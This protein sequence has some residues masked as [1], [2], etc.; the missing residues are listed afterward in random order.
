MKNTNAVPQMLLDNGRGQEGD[1]RK[2]SK[3]LTF[4]DRRADEWRRAADRHAR[5]GESILAMMF[6]N[7]AVFVEAEF[8]PKGKVTL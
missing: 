2:E 7:E 4:Q 1:R 6:R 3:L 5:A 8:S